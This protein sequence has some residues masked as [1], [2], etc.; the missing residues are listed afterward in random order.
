MLFTCTHIVR[1]IAEKRHGK[2]SIKKKEQLYQ[3]IFTLFYIYD[4]D[5]NRYN[6]RNKYNIQHYFIRKQKTVIIKITSKNDKK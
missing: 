3:T 6:L 4:V 1:W 2:K 5:N